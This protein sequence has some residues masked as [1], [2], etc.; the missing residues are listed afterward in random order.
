M[1]RFTGGWIKAWRKA[2]DSDLA[3]NMFL[4]SI[5]NWMLHVATWKPSKIIWKGKQRELP[6]G[7][8]VFGITE[9]AEKWDCSKHTIS[10]WVHYLSE[11]QRIVLETGTD[12]CIATL[13]NWELYQSPEFEEGTLEE[14]EG[15][16]EGTR[17]ERERNLSEEDKKE[18]RKE[19]LSFE[20]VYSEYKKLPGVKKGSKAEQRFE[21]QIKTEDE[22]KSLEAAIQNYAAFLSLPEN[23]WRR[24]KTTFETFLGSKSSGYFWRDFI[25]NEIQAPAPLKTL[26]DLIGGQASA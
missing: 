6:A 11:T 15:N 24:A 4:W 13:C 9:L 14:H 10:R 19:M 17:G 23:S 25:Q 2:V 7:T 21:E 20:A 1:A 12:G 26:E 18:R 22:F 5:W 3:D 8:V 16:A